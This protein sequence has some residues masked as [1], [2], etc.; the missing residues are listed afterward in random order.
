MFSFE[1][2]IF[3][4]SSLTICSLIYL[5]IPQSL[6][7]ALAA[8][9]L[10]AVI[11][12]SRIVFLKSKQLHGQLYRYLL[13]FISALFVQ[14]LVI[15]TGGF[16]SPFVILLYLFTLGISFL[17]NLQ[18]SISFLVFSALTLTANIFLNSQMQAIFRD[19]PWSTIL[20]FISFAI[21]DR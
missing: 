5:R 6:L 12:V 7:Q 8:I 14:L 20:Y 3:L 19:D 21:Y 16:L 10:A 15:T 11:I 9:L 1:I 17:F 2:L 18:S 4:F 13:L